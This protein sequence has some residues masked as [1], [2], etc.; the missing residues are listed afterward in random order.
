MAVSLLITG[1]YRHP[2]MLHANSLSGG[3]L[4]EVLWTRGL[5]YVNEHGTDGFLPSTVPRLLT[6]TNTARRIRGLVGSGLW[7]EVDD[8]WAYH[9]FLE[10]NRPADE[11]QARSA[12][13]SAV[14]SA[15]GKKGA[16]KRWHGRLQP[17]PH[18]PPEMANG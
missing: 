3:D 8:G 17:V 7:L 10:W 4:A 6:P 2:K 1:Y 9:D 16:S 12:A 5:D 11:L 14:R 15:A 18:H 13:L